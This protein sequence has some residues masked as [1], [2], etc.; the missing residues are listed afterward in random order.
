VILPAGK[1]MKAGDPASRQEDE[2]WWFCQQARKDD[3][4]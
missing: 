4:W 2:G 1:K 3:G